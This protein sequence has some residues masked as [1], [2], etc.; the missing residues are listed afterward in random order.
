MKVTIILTCFNRKEKTVQCIKSLMSNLGSSK[1]VSFVVVDDNS[2][3]GTAQEINKMPYDIT[4]LHGDGNL[5]WAGGMRKGIDY[6]LKNNFGSDR[7]FVLLVNDDV[8]FKNG[9]I[10]NMI[11]YIPDNQ[12][13]VV[14]ATCNKNGEQSY[15]MQKSYSN[16]FSARCDDIS[17][18]DT[19]N[20]N[21]GDTFNANCVLI[22]DTVIRKVGNFDVHYKHSLAD[23]DYGFAI[24][25]AGYKIIEY[26]HFVG[27]CEN[28]TLSGTWKDCS[29]S[30]RER[31]KRKESIKGS[32]FSQWF[33][34]LKKNYNIIIA[35][36]YSISPY[37]RILI[38]K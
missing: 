11:K 5:F 34:Y 19:A 37:F 38:G 3:D 33:Y 30:R 10:D 9:I 17:I 7:D 14:G 18:N 8:D 16:M 21:S 23:W 22:P 13:V 12:T 35:L 20:I 25:R 1:S 27:E 28:N 4:I 2:T 6:Y 15:G 26:P 31:L 32:P 24:K 36:R 29:L